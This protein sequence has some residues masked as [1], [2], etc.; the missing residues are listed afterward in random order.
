ML[1]GVI[2][3]MSRKHNIKRMAD[4]LKSGATMLS[5]VCPQCRVPLF[6]LRTGEIIC[7]SCGTRYYIVSDTREET[8]ALIDATI[9]RLERTIMNKLNILNDILRGSPNQSEE[10]MVIDNLIKWLE[11]LERI[12]R[13]KRYTKIS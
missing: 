10:M 3:V 6:K 5:Q 4:L 12:E 9:E 2:E 13:I 7:P 8:K 1:T 11:A